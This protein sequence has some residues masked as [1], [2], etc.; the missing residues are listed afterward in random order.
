MENKFSSLLQDMS[1]I[2]GNI[3][4]TNHK[5]TQEMD[6][7]TELKEKIEELTTNYITL[8]EFYIKSIAEQQGL[9]QQLDELRRNHS[10][11]MMEQKQLKKSR[12]GLIRKHALLQRKFSDM[13]FEFR[14][15]ISVVNDLYKECMQ[16]TYRTTQFAQQLA[17]SMTEAKR[18]YCGRR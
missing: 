4:S 10:V 9:K 7:K 1:E 11:M 16:Q 6:F 14:H 2:R 8:E 3:V 17:S 15:N 5:L 12:D 18:M 13:S